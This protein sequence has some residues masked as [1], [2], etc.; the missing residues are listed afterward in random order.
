MGKA[1]PDDVIEQNRHLYPA[2]LVNNNGTYGFQIDET[3]YTPEQIV[4]MIIEFA[5][6]MTTASVSSRTF[7]DCVVVVSI[8]SERGMF[9][10]F[11]VFQR[12]TNWSML[13]VDSSTFVS[14]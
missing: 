5:H 2:S 7:T 11:L 8:T 4:G 12:L 13:R 1:Y 14:I 9:F 6:R 3:I 10:V